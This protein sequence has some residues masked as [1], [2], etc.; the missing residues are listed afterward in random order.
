MSKKS[1]LAETLAEIESIKKSV[2]ENANYALKST[3]KE[4]LEAIV[5]NGL[6]EAI[7]DIET[8]DMGDET[9]APDTLGMDNDTEEMG[10]NSDEP[11]DDFDGSDIDDEDEFE[12]IDLTDK[13]DDEVI[14]HFNLMDPADEIEIVRTDDGITIKIGTKS[15]EGLEGEMEPDDETEPEDELNFDDDDELEIEMG[16]NNEDGLGDEEDDDDDDQ[17][18]EEETDEHEEPVLGNKTGMSG[19]NS[20]GHNHEVSESETDEH[21]EPILGNKTGMS[22][23]NSAGHDHEVHESTKELQESLIKTRK[24]FSALLTENKQ[25]DDELKKVVTLVEEFKKS[26]NQYKSAIKTLKTQ[27]E[28]VAL[29]TSNLTYA[30][31]LMTENSTT[32]EEKLDILKRFDSAKTLTESREIFN[33]LES[34]FTAK[35]PASKIVEEKVLDTNKTSGAS[36]INESTAYKN[37][38]LSRMLDIIN[39]IK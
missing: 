4:D 30:I 19:D 3:L 16:D 5:K 20:A 22:G 32:K 23:D 11:M 18:N 25:K 27:L 26:E 17:L 29:F 21:E 6:N 2:K 31:K 38:Q 28:E 7:E 12:T 33:S 39:K 37:P 15:G 34:V 10:L 35:K 14:N 1:F 24:K 36:Q 8:N 9:D 13:E